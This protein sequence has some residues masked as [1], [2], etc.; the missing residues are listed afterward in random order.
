MSTA[1]GRLHAATVELTRSCA[2]KQRLATAFSI[3]LKDLD[4]DELPPDLRS[5]FAALHDELECVKPLPGETAVQA[6]VR[7][8]SLE[9]AE[10]I[11]TRIVELYAELLRM[12]SSVTKLPLRDKREEGGAV[13]PLMFAAEA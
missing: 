3:S 6:T 2:L 13:V 10:R 5:A 1:Y 4:A 9:H 7:K 8:M 11:A 12:P